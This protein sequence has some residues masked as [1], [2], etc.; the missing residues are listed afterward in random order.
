MD[1]KFL[2]FTGALLFVSAANAATYYAS[3]YGAAD[4][5]CTEDSPGTL[6]LAVSKAAQ[7]GD[8]VKL[9]AGEY[10][11]LESSLVL[12]VEGIT[13][14]GAS[15]DATQTVIKG[16]GDAKTF[17]GVVVKKAAVMKNLTISGFYAT[18]G[19]SAVAGGNNSA[20][21]ADVLTA[22]NCRIVGNVSSSPAVYGGTWIDCCFASNTNLTSD[23]GAAFAGTYYGCLFTDNYAKGNAGA[24]H[25][26]NVAERCTFVRNE[27]SHVYGGGAVRSGVLRDCIFNANKGKCGGAGSSGTYYNCFFTNNI[28]TRSDGLGGGALYEA[29]TASNCVFIANESKYNG[30]ACYKGKC[31]DCRFKGNSAGYDGGAVYLTTVIGC[32]IE[33]NHGRIG[34]GSCNSV[35]TNCVYSAN[36]PKSGF[37]DAGVA[38]HFGVAVNCL[39]TGNDSL[40]H[41]QSTVSSVKCFNC[42]IAGNKTASS[43]GGI[44]GGSSINT[45]IFDNTKDIVSGAH[46][47]ALYATLSGAS[48]LVDCIQTQNAKFNAGRDASLPYYYLCQNSPAR[49][50]GIDIGWTNKSR[51]L[52]GKKRLVGAVDLGCY[53][54][55]AG[56]FALIVR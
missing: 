36:S 42:T 56:S 18:A 11:R 25:S 39:F 52:R 14:E 13:V 27:S 41:A 3:P 23:G 20:T 32:Y 5:A 55:Q 50:A 28:A 29:T 9:A 8:V 19:G 4:A 10:G 6:E 54:Y 12:N 34:S 21:K 17:T 15:D 48:E 37:T 31:F 51:D 38:A 7:A 43:Q 26:A 24:V 46:T 1:A 53:E 44:R 35:A 40:T 45:I 22:V 16:P 2:F 49:N 47:N 33:S 30:G